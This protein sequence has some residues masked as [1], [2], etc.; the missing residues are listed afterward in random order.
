MSSG[1]CLRGP[2]PPLPLGREGQAGSRVLRGTFTAAPLSS[3]ACPGAAELPGLP[4]VPAAGQ[5]MHVVP[6]QVLVTGLGERGGADATALPAPLLPRG[7]RSC[8]P[9]PLT[10]ADRGSV[11]TRPVEAHTL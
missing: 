1:S 4:G 5:S 6:L 7:P 8:P 9:A 10:R 11:G 3:T 2:I